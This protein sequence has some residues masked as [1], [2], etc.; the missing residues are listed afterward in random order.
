MTR[1]KFILFFSLSTLFSSLVW[2]ESTTVDFCLNTWYADSPNIHGG[3]Y[4]TR[5]SGNN[6][7]LSTVHSAKNIEKAVETLQQ[8]GYQIEFS[9]DA[10]VRAQ[11]KKKWDFFAYSKLPDGMSRDRLYLFHSRTDNRAPIKKSFQKLIGQ[12]VLNT[13]PYHSFSYENKIEGLRVSCHVI[14]QDETFQSSK[15]LIE[16]LGMERVSDFVGLYGNTTTEI[17]GDTKF[18]LAYK[19]NGQALESATFDGVSQF[20][21]SCAVEKNN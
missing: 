1:L 8:A 3:Y 6:L 15:S 17:D 12:P 19:S 9:S 11:N 5:C 18:Y 2:A 4:N 14:T 16:Y 21:E 20:Q 7:S 13:F 10:N